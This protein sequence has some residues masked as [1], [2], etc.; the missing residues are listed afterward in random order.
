M[1]ANAL[2]DPSPD[3]RMRGLLGVIFLKPPGC[4]PRVLELLAGFMNELRIGMDL[5]LTIEPLYRDE[6]TEEEFPLL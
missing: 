2:D 4:L 6:A 1:A 5:E 3:V